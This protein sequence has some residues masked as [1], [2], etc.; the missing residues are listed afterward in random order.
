MTG[1]T[2]FVLCNEEAQDSPVSENEIILFDKGQFQNTDIASVYYNEGHV[3]L[4]DNQL[5]I[6]EN[7]E[8]HYGIIVKGI[9][10]PDRKV[11]IYAEIKA[12]EST[13][14]P[15]IQYGQCNENADFPSVIAQGTNRISFQ[16]KSF[17]QG[18]NLFIKLT[19]LRNG[20]NAIFF[21]CSGLLGSKAEIIKISKITIEKRM[22]IIY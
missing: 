11:M 17:A 14:V 10:V 9:T 19:L 4:V 16:E 21:G 12:R 5:L 6:D 15:W 13:D 2:A 1:N 18:D 8:E 7:E 20:L 22:D 3:N